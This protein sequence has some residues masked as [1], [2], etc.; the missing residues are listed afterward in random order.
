MDPVVKKESLYVA[1]GT[2]ALSVIVQLVWALFFDYG[3]PVFLG[4][5]WGG[6]C[7]V[8]NFVLLGRAVSKAA[9]DGDELLARRRLHASYSLRMLIIALM[10][11]VAVTVPAINWVMAVISLV[12]PRLT[13]LI[14]PVFRKELREKGGE[15]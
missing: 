5:L 11:V 12:F 8:L 15:K 7:A 13:I 4:G 9:S 2:A 6:A 1:A 3:L 14:E 10:V